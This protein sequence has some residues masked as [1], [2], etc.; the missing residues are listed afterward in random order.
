MESLLSKNSPLYKLLVIL[1]LVLS[2]ATTF[3]QESRLRMVVGAGMANGGEVIGNGLIIVRG[4]NHTIPFELKAGNDPQYRLGLECLLLS[5]LSLQSTVGY[6]IT[7]PMG[8]N[9]SVEF[10]TVPLELLAFVKITDGLR[11]GAGLR[12]SKAEIT[13]SGV[14]ANW[15]V[16]GSYSSTSGK[17]LEFQYLFSAPDNARSFA[18]TQAG[19]SVRVV[20]EDL[21]RNGTIYS[22]NHYELGLVVY[23]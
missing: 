11:L 20:N 19:F 2:G 14:A 3:G 7:D 13:G 16:L 6:S 15:P 9:G 18:K 17:V 4:T 1:L 8:D 12:K 23:F 22:G 5:G 21:S 10:T